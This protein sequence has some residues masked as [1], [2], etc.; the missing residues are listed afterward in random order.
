MV[1]PAD[2][3][4]REPGSGTDPALLAA[5]YDNIETRLVLR[6]EATEVTSLFAGIGIVLLVAG[7]LAGL[8]WLGRLP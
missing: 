8:V 7:G 4:D 2:K 3:P 6:P 5:I 1:A